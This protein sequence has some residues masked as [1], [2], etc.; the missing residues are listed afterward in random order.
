MNMKKIL[1]VLIGIFLV[2]SFAFAD[3][4]FRMRDYDGIEVP[5][6]TFIRVIS[7]QDFSSAY[8]DSTNKLQ[9]AAID[10]TFQFET[11]I[12]PRGT[13]FE[14]VV[15]KKNEPVIGTHGSL[16]VRINQMKLPDGFIIPV[17]GYINTKNG[18]IIGGEMTEPEKYRRAPHYHEKIARH[19]VGVL[20]MV[21]GECRKMG[22]HVT[23]SSGAGLF[24]LFV[25]PVY[26]THTLTD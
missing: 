11:K 4:D 8:T 24:I 13:V 9:F 23:V 19:F 6:G 10:D 16:V 17:R 7:L 15:E 20:Q 26:I 14:G 1:L 18:N 2:T 3:D 25:E 5:R 12:I 22:E 21:P